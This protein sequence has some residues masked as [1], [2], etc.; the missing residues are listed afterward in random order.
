VKPTDIGVNDVLFVTGFC[1]YLTERTHTCRMAPG[2]IIGIVV[3]CR[4]YKR[5]KGLQKKSSITSV[6]MVT[7]TQPNGTSE[8]L[9]KLYEKIRLWGKLFKDLPDCQ[10]PL[11]WPIFK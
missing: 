11:L 9:V 7:G 2:F 5:N 3:A 4:G 8:S 6:T 1:Y 10:Q